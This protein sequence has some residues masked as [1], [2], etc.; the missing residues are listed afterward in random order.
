MMHEFDW[1]IPANPAVVMTNASS[2]P[3]PDIVEE[4]GSEDEI[5][6][7][8]YYT[9]RDFSGV[10]FKGYPKSLIEL[11]IANVLSPPPDAT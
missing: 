11:Y 5:E 3:A 2:I 1:L 10:D 7:E 6:H 8:V 4:T 9:F